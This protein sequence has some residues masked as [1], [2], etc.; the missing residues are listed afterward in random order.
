MSSRIKYFCHS[1]PFVAQSHN[2]CDTVAR[3]RPATNTA[4]KLQSAGFPF[5]HKFSL[6]ARDIYLF[7]L[8]GSVCGAFISVLVLY[9]QL[10]SSTLY[11]TT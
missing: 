4:E 11:L 1:S 6:A 9:V 8:F 3:D 5:Q 7:A 10:Q 2:K